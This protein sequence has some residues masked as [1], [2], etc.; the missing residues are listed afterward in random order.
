L[1]TVCLLVDS[2]RGIGD[3]DKTIM[4]ELDMAAVSWVLVLTK[5]DKLN[6][7]ELKKVKEESH[8][9]ISKHP[10]SYPEIMITSSLKNDGL[11]SLRTYLA[12]FA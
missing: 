4:K 12:S 8:E 6:N 11:S 5:V 9:I 10:A 2:R 1:R 3:H 7:E